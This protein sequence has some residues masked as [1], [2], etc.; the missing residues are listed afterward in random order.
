M[1]LE[2]AEI[3]QVLAMAPVQSLMQSIVAEDST[4]QGEDDAVNTAV[5]NLIQADYKAK[6]CKSKEE[7]D[8]ELKKQN[9]Q[10]KNPKA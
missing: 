2:G 7:F 1:I 8:A 5:K 6:K 9:I 3:G 10:C 4:I